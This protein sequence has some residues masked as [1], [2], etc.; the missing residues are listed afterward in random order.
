M[1]KDRK[2]AG[3]AVPAALRPVADL[4]VEERCDYRAGGGEV[5]LRASRSRSS[6]AMAFPAT[7]ICP[8]TGRRDMDPFETEPE[9]LLYSWSTVHVSAQRQVPYTIGYVDF[10]C[11]LRVLA[12]VRWPESRGGTGSW[13]CDLPVRLQADEREWWVEP[14]TESGGRIGA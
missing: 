14:V 11:G 12:Q 4:A 10:A 1:N 5:R 3:E 7:G 6:G 8:E 13:G 9:G 2:E